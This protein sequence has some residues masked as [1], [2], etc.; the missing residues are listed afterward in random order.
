VPFV[1]HTDVN[2]PRRVRRVGH[3][4]RG[5]AHIDRGVAAAR[6][7]GS[8]YKDVLHADLEDPYLGIGK[9]LNEKYPFGREEAKRCNAGLGA[10]LTN[11]Y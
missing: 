3:I 11:S 10:L 7:T 4:D 6:V 8:I 2:S 9:M 5:V 1:G